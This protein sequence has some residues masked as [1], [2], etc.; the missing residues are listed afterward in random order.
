LLPPDCVR[1]I[2]SRAFGFRLDR[3]HEEDAL[4]KSRV[5]RPPPMKTLLLVDVLFAAQYDDP[6]K[7]D[8]Q[9]GTNDSNH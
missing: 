3:K 1:A 8:R 7:Q 9:Y 2:Y 6:E 4:S 5:S